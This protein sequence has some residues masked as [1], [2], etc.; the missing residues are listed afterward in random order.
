MSEAAHNDSLLDFLNAAPTPFHAVRVMARNLETAGF[1]RLK[2]TESWPLETGGRYYVT[3]NDSSL[4]AWRQGRRTLAE[5]GLRLAGAHTDSPCLRLKPNPGLA[6]NG[7]WRLSVE[8]Y[9]GALL[10]PWFDRDLSLAGRVSFLDAAGS[11][12]HRLLDWR[13]PIAVIPS[14]AIHLDRDANKNRSV[15]PQTDLPPLLLRLP[16]GLAAPDFNAFLLERLRDE[17]PDAEAQQ[18]LD[19]ELS[20]YDTQPADLVGLAG[21]FIAGARLDNLLSCHAG[22]SAL[23][24]A[25]DEQPALLVCN[26]HE[27]VGSRSTAGADGAFL[28]S[29]LA[30]MEP[31]PELRARM[32]ARSLLISTDN[33]HGLHPSY[34]DKHDTNHGPLLNEGPVIK[35]N[36]GQR[37]ATTSETA[38]LF[39]ALCQQAGV[40]LQAYAVRADMACGSTI[41]PI[42]AAALGVRTLDVGVATF[43]MHSVREL[44][45]ARDPWLLTQ[46]LSACFAC[47]GW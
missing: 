36:H 21:E 26:D 27:E 7:Y 17:H 40:P 38:A 37:Y 3:R 29:V 19:A 23:L 39:R 46:A 32:L 12:Q 45:G 4:I 1:L 25:G 16:A 15:N 10:N 20:C 18:V 22:L 11:V 9:G 43:A 44:A 28:A 47:P 33:A 5:S 34:P 30:R 13:R 6:T 14:L 41:G 8:V 42:T 2:E 31:D 35:V 24:G